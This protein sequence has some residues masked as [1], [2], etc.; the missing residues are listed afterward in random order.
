VTAD[1]RLVLLKGTRPF[2]LWVDDVEGLVAPGPEAF[3]DVPSTPT[4]A[5]VARIVRLGDEIVP[6]LAPSA[7]EPPAA[8]A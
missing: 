8:A 3:S 7:L 1:H 6:L 2:L 5:V 4:D